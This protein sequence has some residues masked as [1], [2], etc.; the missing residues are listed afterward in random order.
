MLVTVNGEYVIV[1]RVQHELLET[2]ISVYN[3]EVEDYHTYYVAADADSEESGVLVH[4]KC[5]SPDDIYGSV[6]DSPSYRSDFIKAPNGTMKVKI[7]NREVLSELNK[8]GKRWKKVYSD[9]YLGGTKASL[10]FFQDATG[11]VFNIKYKI[12]WSVL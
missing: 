5:I 12:G 7:N 6:K 2:P 11:K 10:H 1:E 4:N 9:G 8:Y 3:F